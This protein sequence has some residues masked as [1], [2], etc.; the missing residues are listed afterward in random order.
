MLPVVSRMISAD[1][2]TD[3]HTL[4]LCIYLMHFLQKKEVWA[5]FRF[6]C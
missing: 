6:V 5:D 3:G 2:Q 1:R 4:P